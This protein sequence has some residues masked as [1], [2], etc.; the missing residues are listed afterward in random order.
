MTVTHLVLALGLSA[1]ILFGVRLEERDLIAEHPEY[2]MYRR[3]V[4][5]F[6]PGIRG[7]PSTGPRALSGA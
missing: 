3:R 7:N 2:E 4:P 5:M 1:H 6:I